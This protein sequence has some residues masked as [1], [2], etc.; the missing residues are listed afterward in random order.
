MHPLTAIVAA[1]ERAGREYLAHCTPNQK[2]RWIA[3]MQEI[4]EV[5]LSVITVTHFE[6]AGFPPASLGGLQLWL[7]TRVEDLLKGVPNIKVEIVC[8]S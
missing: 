8:G 4:N 3:S 6:A 2:L 5:A 1:G 7:Q